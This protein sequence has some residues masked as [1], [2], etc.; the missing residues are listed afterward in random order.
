MANLAVMGSFSVNGISREQSEILKRRL[1]PAYS[2][3]FQEKFCNKTAGIAH[4]RW[5]MCANPRLSELICSAI[6]QR[7]ITEP[8]ALTELEKFADDPGFL[9]SLQKIKTQ[10]KEHLASCLKEFSMSVDDC[11]VMFDI[12]SGKI[13]PYKRQVLHVLYILYRYLKIK[14]GETLKYRRLHVFAGKASPSD[15]LA[16][17]IIHLINVTKNLVNNDPEINKQ[18]QIVFVPNFGMSWAEKILPSA[19]LSEQIAT[20]SFEAG[21]TFNMKFA[22]NGT[23]TIA[24]RCGSNLEL[25]EKV[26]LENISLFGKSSEELYNIGDYRPQEYLQSDPRLSSIFSLL[27]SLLPSLSDG[28]TIYPLISSLRDNDR[29]F[30][31]LDFAD[32]VQ[33]QESIDQLFA[34]KQM[35]SRAC[36]MNIARSGYFS[37]DRATLEY[38]REIWKVI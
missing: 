13:H 26:G 31:L 7:W 1:F 11:S 6:G 29:Y 34:D 30:V 38:A 23:Y 16:K 28:S 3:Y 4:R 17:Q 5:L 21:G 36:L 2:A 25:A 19:D 10:A 15:F 12:Q 20:A 22:F 14:A 35:W 27:E 24:S 18:M 37:S 32:Y 33:K 8:M 9:L